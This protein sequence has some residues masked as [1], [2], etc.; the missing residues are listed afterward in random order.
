MGQVDLLR[1]LGSPLAIPQAAV[2]EIQRGGPLDAGVQ[3]LASAP[4]IQVVNPS[5]IPGTIQALNLG[6]GESAVLAYAL[7]NAGGGVIIDDR[8]A[9]NAAAALGIP[10]QGTLGL[11][12]FAKR[13]GV[14][15]AARP[16]LEQLRQHGMFLSDKL[17]NAVLGQVGE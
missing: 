9:R 12:L 2:D 4:W 1:H 17:M 11:V 10:Y 14:L 5:P 7:A 16:V 8:A 13:Q 6:N 3:A 15:S